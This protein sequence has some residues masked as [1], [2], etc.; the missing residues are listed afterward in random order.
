MWLE[1]ALALWR[2]VRKASSKKV[3]WKLATGISTGTAFQF[4]GTASAKA[5]R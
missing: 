2:V 5:L 3:A 1:G 4:E